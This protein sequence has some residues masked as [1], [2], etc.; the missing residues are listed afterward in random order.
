[1]IKK[2]KLSILIPARNEEWLARTVE[3]LLE[4]KTDDTEIIVGL[5]GK[6]ADPGLPDH[7]DVTIVYY[8]ESI[9]QRQMTNQLCKLSNAKY[10]A[11]VDAH[12]AFDQDFDKKMLDA[13]KITGDNVVMVPIMRNLHAFD[14]VCPDGHRRYQG[15]SGPCKECGKPTERDV[16]WIPKTSPQSKSYSFDASPHFQYFS[17][18]CKREPF[19]KDLE[20]D[21]LTE[22][23]SI[24]GS[25]FMMTKDNYYELDIDNEEWG[26][27]GSQGIQIAC[28]FW[29]S[30]GRVI[31][32]NNTWYAHMFRTQGQDF[33][34]PYP[35]S[36]RQVSHAKKY[37]KKIFF[38][39][40]WYK[41]IRPVSW[42]VERFWPVTYW[43]DE[44]LVA[45]KEME[46][47]SWGIEKKDYFRKVEVECANC[48]NKY[49]VKPS[50]VSKTTCCSWDCL[51][52]YKRKTYKGR[53][54]TDEWKKNISESKKGEK[55]PLWKGKDVG[56]K[57]LH[58]WVRREKGNPIK[59]QFCDSTFCLNWANKSH[60]YK[61]DL[62]DWIPLCKKC[63]WK[64][65]NLS[66]SIIFYTDNQLQL[67]I[68]HRVQKQ[69]LKIS[70]DKNIP[71]VSASLKPMPKMG[72]NIHLPL[73]RG[74]LTMFK[75]IL[76]AL[77]ASTAEIIYFCEHDVMYS[78]SHFD[79][80][81]EHKEIFYYNT[82]WWKIRKDGKAVSWGAN[83]VSGLCA[84]RSHLL[85]FYRKR[86]SELEKKG[87]DRSYEPGRRD[88]TLYETWKSK[89]PNIDIR[90]EG[91]LTRGKWSKDDFRDK[92]TCIDWQE[93]TIDKIDG[94][95]KL[96]SFFK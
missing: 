28:S 46:K 29:L 74:V 45:L 33:G 4:H 2:Y 35:Q 57:A 26:S 43:K 55:H 61:R 82:A 22:S 58:D 94:W 25:F 13:F 39:E 93:T 5:D 85:N 36:G 24:Q 96:D 34:F 73:K 10:I 71:I 69:L 6:W 59:C 23:M 37:A 19:K 83:Q 81:P 47:K 64:Y 3:D 21:G 78:E 88:K 66:R 95:T 12:C 17:E 1:M 91:T 40:R 72:K 11:K 52:E 60:D 8:P 70:K 31:V 32:N 14:W 15:P 62:N 68:A 67:K 54:L 75:Q 84:Y 89:V 65:D 27:W 9:G 80:V 48:G 7:D 92:S 30:G 50:R 51:N 86:V 56:Y 53:K 49:E 79:F 18:H 38:E 77:E 87:I 44:D 63:H 41:A 16:V 42:I 76:A 90:H 20:R